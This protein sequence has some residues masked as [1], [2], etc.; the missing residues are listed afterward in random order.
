MITILNTSDCPHCEQK[1]AGVMAKVV[2]KQIEMGNLGEDV[3]GHVMAQVYTI[4][5][6]RRPPLAG[7]RIPAVR[8]YTDLCNKCG[9]P[10]NFLIEEGHAALPIRPGDVPVFS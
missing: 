8:V 5:D 10:F 4:I 1:D 9:R 3:I 7:A 2:K 6:G